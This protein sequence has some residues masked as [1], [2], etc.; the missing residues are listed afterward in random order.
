MPLSLGDSG[1]SL[2][3]VSKTQ[4]FFLEQWDSG[5][6]SSNPDLLGPGEFLDK[7]SL[8]NCLGGRFSP[9]ID[10]FRISPVSSAQ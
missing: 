4:Y 3:S 9:G 6:C 5:H 1:Q 8:I 10:I 7:A 2:L